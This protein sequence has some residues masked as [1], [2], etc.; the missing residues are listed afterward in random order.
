M[1]KTL[2]RV[3]ST[4]SL[5]AAIVGL[6]ALAGGE[7]NAAAGFETGIL[8]CKSVPGTRVNLLIHSTEDIKCVFKST[9]GNL[10]QHRSE[11][12]TSELQSH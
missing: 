3:L 12:H 6:P 10:V 9:V 11:E 7:A 4:L 1:M 8:T 2:T 5:T